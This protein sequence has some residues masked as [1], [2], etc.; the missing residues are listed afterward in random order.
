MFRYRYA[1]RLL[2]SLGLFV[3]VFALGVRTA[4][5]SHFR[6]GTMYWERDLTYSNPASPNQVKVRITIEIGERWSYPFGIPPNAS[7]LG[8]VSNG[9]VAG[10][11]TPFGAVLTAGQATGSGSCP[12]PGAVVSPSGSTGAGLNFSKA[13][14]VI[15]SNFTLGTT[16][17]N[18]PAS[19]VGTTG[20]TFYA[21]VTQTVPS[22]DTAYL[23]SIIDVIVDATTA[24]AASPLTVTWQD[25]C[26]LASI[27]DNNVNNW[28][29]QTAI[30]LSAGNTKSPRSQ[31]V[32]FIPVVAGLSNTITLPSVTFDNLT[33]RFRL[34]TIAESDLAAA[35][36]SSP[37]VFGLN[38][39]TGVVTFKPRA[40]GLYAVQFQVGGADSNNIVHNETPLDVIFS[41]SSTSS[42]TSTLTLG[43]EDAQ[44]TYTATVPQPFSFNTRATLLPAD[45]AATVTVT[46]TVL[47]AGAV[48]SQPAGTGAATQIATFT[49]TPTVSSTGSVVCFQATATKG[50]SVVAL[51]SQLCVTIKLS[52]LATSMTAFAA[53]GDGGGP[54]LL[55]ARLVRSVDNTPLPGRQV[56]FLWTTDPTNPPWVSDCNP[57][58]VTDTNGIAR[59][60]VITT[61]TVPAGGPFTA[62]FD[63][64][65]N[66][67]VTSS[68][69]SSTVVIKGAT[70]TLNAPTVPTNPFNSALNPVTVSAVLNR[71]D[72]DGGIY[73][74]AGQVVQF[75]LIDPNGIETEVDG[76]VAG[77]QGV[78][79]ATFT[80]DAAPVLGD[81]HVRAYFAG[82]EL[83]F[84]DVTSPTTTFAMGQRINLTAAPATG[85]VNQLTALRAR[86]LSDPQGVPVAAN[87][88]TFRFGT[89]TLQGTT[90]AD[91]W[92]QVTGTFTI[93]GSSTFTAAFT[94]SAAQN[95]L[96]SL[97]LRATETVNG[98][99]TVTP[100]TATVLTTS[101]FAGTSWT[102]ATLTARLTT[103][104]SLLAING[105]VVAFSVNG[106]A[107]GAVSTDANGVASLP[108]TPGNK[109]SGQ[110]AA[111]F[112]GQPN[113][114]LASS[115]TSSYVVA[116]A[117]SV[118]VVTCTSPVTFNGAGQ[119]PCTAIATGAGGL[120]EPLVV[121]YT[122]NLNAGTATA[123][124][125][126]AGDTSHDGSNGTAS[127]TIG[128]AATTTVVTCPTT[129]VTFTG[130]AQ[131]PCTATVTGDGALSQAVSVAYT[132]NFNA[133]TASASASF[134]GDGNHSGSTGAADFTI[135]VATSTTL[136]ICPATVTYNGSAQAPCSA[137]VTGDGGLTQSAPVSYSNNINAGPASA[138]AT[139][140][141]DPNHTASDG[142][143]TFTIGLA[144][145]ATM[146]T[147]PTT[148]VT[149]TGSAQAP[150]TA[151]ATGDGGLSQ[152][153][154]VSYTNNTAAGTASASASYAGDAN[155]VPSS[156]ST[157][158]AISK[159]SSVVTVTC[160]A[161]VTFTG[162]AQTPCT[163]A[164]N[165]DGGLSQPVT[166]SYTGNLNAG[167]ANATASFAGDANHTGSNRSATF[168]IARATPMVTW[169][170]PAAI[171]Y[172]TALGGTQLNA[173]ATVP[174]SFA[175]T[176]VAGSVPAVGTQTLS[177]VFT[178]G[179]AVDYTTAAS[180]VTLAVGA[181]SASSL[182]VLVS[183]VETDPQVAASLN[184]IL[185]LAGRA[186][187]GASRGAHLNKFVRDVTSQIGRTLTNAQAQALIQVAN[188]LY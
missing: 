170:A 4:S 132:S 137:T 88:V 185:S 86:L 73:P 92:A 27:L 44:T 87:A 163:A 128:L 36:P 58:A 139:Y 40:A 15:G 85:G 174:G 160:A 89:T 81:Y 188:S 74:P 3:S 77:L 176:P 134:A 113:V 61:R 127:F 151:T 5:A 131:M 182:Q 53:S 45:A 56:R 63:A 96:N 112:A 164:V 41:A 100:A 175:Y 32:P 60:T 180:S 136:V 177:V 49:W 38:A 142:S 28:Q 148:S 22:Q 17:V 71:V 51:S 95:Q 101:A 59:C 24:T 162:S 14:T 93:V 172:G 126:F 48:F 130:S 79:T 156:A 94:P 29:L 138:T 103:G 117:P 135:G 171:S 80:A 124:A 84:G 102:P 143:M 154:P 99:V 115:A 37:S 147:C 83:L 187:N 144:L 181:A 150:C 46:S 11:C 141:G 146:V 119:M 166:V 183:A 57:P 121:N 155:H 184:A 161:P 78:A 173:T 158:F 8:P 21:M 120:S 39:S 30:N 167:T 168:T 55:S 75:T 2:V 106:V 34:A 116:N 19:A 129:P 145:S 159:A 114:Y 107:V 18:V 68:A 13:V 118:T 110:Y 76:V 42:Q 125:S 165:G 7:Q 26:R 122:H 108:I 109:V 91:G 64:I 82:N 66:E 62:T 35:Q 157:T 67:L 153:L 43:T 33:P 16:P 23:R 149:F 97:G 65:A 72:A 169:A 90:D 6:Y 179:D 123:S 111:A 105:A 70:T 186:P 47:P 10:A 25:C 9:G 20:Y 178:P 54:L 152:S 133:G 1:R 104:S 50:Q 140:A 98:T 69:A 52:P 12:P 31:S